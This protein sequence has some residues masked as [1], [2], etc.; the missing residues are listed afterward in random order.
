[1][2]RETS[3]A[4]FR[5]WQKR[6][7]V[8]T[9][10]EKTIG[11][12]KVEFIFKKPNGFSLGGSYSTRCMAKP[13]ASVDLLLHLPKKVEWSAL[14]NEA[15]KPVLVVFPGNAVCFRNVEFSLVEYVET[16]V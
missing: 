12:D 16:A 4:C 8:E 13:D 9:G 7:E 5:G 11:A 3:C 2:V 14:Q 1:M 6:S 15:R 10:L